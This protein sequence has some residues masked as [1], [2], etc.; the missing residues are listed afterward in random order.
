VHF[1]GRRLVG[2]EVRVPE[3][4]RGVA[5][6]VAPDHAPG[7]DGA[8]AGRAR[9]DD[10]GDDDEERV[11]T[12]ATEEV[13]GFERMVVWRHGVAADRADDRYVR[14]IEE[15]VGFATA[16]SGDSGVWRE[17]NSKHRYIPNEVG[18]RVILVYY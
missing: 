3:G 6:R 12:G 8:S 14:G 4:Y 2:A 7:P 5:M 10:G 17:A 18:C 1:R 16:V 13:A 15:W 11:E 9:A